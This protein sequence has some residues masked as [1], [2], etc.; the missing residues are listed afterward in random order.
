MC[1]PIP[2]R[3]AT[4]LLLAL[5]RADGVRARAGQTINSTLP[6][7]RRGPPHSPATWSPSEEGA[8]LGSA[9]TRSSSQGGA[10][11]GGDANS[12]LSSALCATNTGARC[13]TTAASRVVGVRPV[14]RGGRLAP[15]A[16]ALPL[17]AA[18]ALM[19]RPSLR[20]SSPKIP[21]HLA[22]QSTHWLEKDLSADRRRNTRSNI[23]PSDEATA[24]LTGTLSADH[25]STHRSRYDRKQSSGIGAEDTSK[26]PTADLAAWMAAVTA[27][28]SAGSSAPPR[29]VARMQ[30][31]RLASSFSHISLA[32]AK[33]C[34]RSKGNVPAVHS[35]K[36]W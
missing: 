13:G 20:H 3:S 14:V 31:C 15:R 11:R 36:A 1:Y 29:R 12:L 28:P 17:T 18:G 21:V 5:A 16:G 23:A 6:N 7:K 24:E 19:P 33:S 8:T 26:S 10:T 32:A 27:A 30:I 34:G 22:D 25:C 35:K 2:A 4:L 9:G